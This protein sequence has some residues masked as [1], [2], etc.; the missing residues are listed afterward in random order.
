VDLKAYGWSSGFPGKADVLESVG[1]GRVVDPCRCMAYS[2]KDLLRAMIPNHPAVPQHYT[3][4]I[5]FN[6]TACWQRLQSSMTEAFLSTRW[7]QSSISSCTNSGFCCC[8]NEISITL[9]F[10]MSKTIVG[11]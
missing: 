7:S 8:Q 3:V 6:S 1:A 10:W 5:S 9:Q 4:Y 11:D 2:N